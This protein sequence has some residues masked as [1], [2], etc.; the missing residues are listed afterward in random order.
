MEP[1]AGDRSLVQEAYRK[2]R[3]LWAASGALFLRRSEQPCPRGRPPGGV[4][5]LGPVEVSD[6]A[7]VT[8][9]KPWRPL[10]RQA[11]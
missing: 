9:T 8:A 1:R 11:G 4:V 2:L 3:W 10:A 7:S 5:P 6:S